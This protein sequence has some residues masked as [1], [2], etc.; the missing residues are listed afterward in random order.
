MLF[1]IVLQN[2]RKLSEFEEIVWT[3]SLKNQIYIH[4]GEDTVQTK[5]NIKIAKLKN[6]VYIHI[7]TIHNLIII[8]KWDFVS[9]VLKFGANN[10]LF[11]YVIH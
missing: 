5:M 7:Y 2:F 8:F 3:T 11:I 10:T 1:I 9:A 4:E 6:H